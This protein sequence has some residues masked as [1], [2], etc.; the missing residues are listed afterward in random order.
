MAPGGGYMKSVT[1]PRSHELVKSHFVLPVTFSGAKQEN[2]PSL[3][4][5]VERIIVGNDIIDGLKSGAIFSTIAP[6]SFL[7]YLFCPRPQERGC[8]CTRAYFSALLE[9]NN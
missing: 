3:L 8:H 2:F 4:H 9:V 6:A 7:R 5:S 1:K